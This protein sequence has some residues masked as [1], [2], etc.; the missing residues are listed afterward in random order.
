MNS[1]GSLRSRPCDT[2]VSKPLTDR[3]IRQ[4]ILEGHYGWKAQQTALK[5]QAAKKKKPKLKH[6]APIVD[7][8]LIPPSVSSLL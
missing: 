2:L 6:S 3:K 4:Y 7:D 5:A 8:K 1:S